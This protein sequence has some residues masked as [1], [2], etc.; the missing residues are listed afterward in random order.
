MIRRRRVIYA[1]I[2]EEVQK[3]NSLSAS[4][5]AQE[6]AFPPLLI[7]MVAAGELGGTLDSS[8]ASMAVYFE[9]EN[10]LNNKIRSASVY[11]IILGVVSVAVVL[12]LVTLVL[13]TITSMFDPELMPLPTKIIMGISSFILN[14]WLLLLLLVGVLFFGVSMLLKVDSIRLRFDQMKLQLPVIGKLLRTIY[15]ARA[16]RAMA[17]LYSSGIQTLDMIETT[18]KVLNNRFLESQFMDILM[19]VSKGEL[20][21]EAIEKTQSFDP[22]FS[23]MIFIGEESGSLDNILSDTADYFDE[24]ADAAT[25]KRL[26]LEPVCRGLGGYWFHCCFDYYADIYNVFFRR[27]WSVMLAIEF[28]EDRILLVEGKAKNKKITV[29]KTHSF[30]FDESWTNQQGVIQVDVLADK[31]DSELKKYGFKGRSDVVI[32]FNHFNSIFRDLRVPYVEGKRLD[33]LVRTEMMNTLNLS[34]D[35]FD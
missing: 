16:A 6:G 11:P 17:S 5:M 35:F 14:N 3:G 10:K 23:S 33:V 27:R 2:Y 31:L 26:S 18:G 22:M 15:S 19:Q 24:E 20:I 30:S 8:L 25:S 12:M 1:N 4:M 28:T 34:N 7:N 13:P 21:S 32:C 29:K 9:K